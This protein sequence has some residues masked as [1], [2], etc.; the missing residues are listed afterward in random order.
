MAKK[1]ERIFYVFKGRLQMRKILKETAFWL[2]SIFIL[3]LF[4]WFQMQVIRSTEGWLETVTL[5]GSAI[6]E[7]LLI[8]QLNN[9]LG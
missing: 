4:G 7:L 8:A 2:L 5:C 1:T 6:L 9:L 3:V